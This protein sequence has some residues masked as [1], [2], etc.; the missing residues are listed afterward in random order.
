MK[1]YESTFV[2][3]A[4][5]GGLTTMSDT[6]VIVLPMFVF[7][8]KKKLPCFWRKQDS[9]SHLRNGFPLATFLVA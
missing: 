8:G 6:P 7:I 5:V 1:Y 3:L 2:I 9:A 4:V